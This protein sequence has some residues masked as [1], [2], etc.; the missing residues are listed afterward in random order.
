MGQVLVGGLW[1]LTICAKGVSTLDLPRQWTLGFWK[2]SGVQVLVMS[3][4][5]LVVLRRTGGETGFGCNWRSE[6]SGYALVA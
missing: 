6:F 2:S 4:F 5:F 3:S 1:N